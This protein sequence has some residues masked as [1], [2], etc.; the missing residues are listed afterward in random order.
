MSNS[1]KLWTVAHQ[2]STRLLCLWDSPG[3][4]TGVGCYF[5]LQGIFPTQGWNPHLLHLLHWQ[6][7]SL[8]LAP[9]GSDDEHLFIFLL[10][11]YIP[12]SVKCLVIL[13]HFLFYFLTIFTVH[14]FIYFLPGCSLS[15][16]PNRGF[17][18][19]NSFNFDEV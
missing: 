6:E 9:P 3:K 11:I 1:E 10:V 4:N 12:S 16:H 7:G 13:A 2:Q 14:L 8:P 15:F 17:H 18:R 19:A 5:L